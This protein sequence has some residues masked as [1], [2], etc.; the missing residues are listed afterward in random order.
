MHQSRQ[1]CT[2]IIGYPKARKTTPSRSSES[3]TTMAGLRRSCGAG[4]VPRR[5]DPHS[6]SGSSEGD[7]VWS[8]ASRPKEKGFGCGNTRSLSSSELAGLTL[9]AQAVCRTDL[10]R[11]QCT[12]TR[13]SAVSPNNAMLAGSGTVLTWIADWPSSPPPISEARRA[14]VYSPMALGSN[15]GNVGAVRNGGTLVPRKPNP[16]FCESCDSVAV[17]SIALKL[18]T[19]CAESLARDRTSRPGAGQDAND[20]TRQSRLTSEH[21]GALPPRV[22][23]I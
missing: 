20:S 10:R 14:N 7:C 13:P 4:A 21:V 12:P 18:I 2:R 5:S 19:P 1:R 9:T 6:D 3:A 23:Q 16:R 11:R 22:N 15:D 8:A 17:G